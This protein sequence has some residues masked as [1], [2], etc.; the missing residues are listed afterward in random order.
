[1]VVQQKGPSFDDGPKTKK[2][3]YETNIEL[4][5]L[6][7]TNWFYCSLLINFSRLQKITTHLFYSVSP[8]R[9]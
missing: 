6:H 9:G 5:N 1:M 4:M 2:N 8:G 3:P 7:Y